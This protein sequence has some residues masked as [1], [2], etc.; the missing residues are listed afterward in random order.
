MPELVMP[1]PVGGERCIRE[2]VC[3]HTKRI[4]DSC[5]DKDC[6]ECLRV[7]PTKSAQEALDRAVSVRA[8]CAQLICA[9]IDVEEVSFNRGYYA[10]DVRYYYRITADAYLGAGRPVEV[11]GLAVFDKRVVL[12]GGE[13][14]AK[15]FTSGQPCR[16]GG[17]AGGPEAVV[18]T[19]AYKLPMK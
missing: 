7:Y 3:I 18:D 8:G 1:G 11:N 12:C 2:A 9:Y 14:G 5:R 15:V 19:V 16:F 13:S 10:V 4:T 17:D 6:L